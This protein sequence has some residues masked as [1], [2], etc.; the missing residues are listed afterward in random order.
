MPSHIGSEM[1]FLAESLHMRRLGTE[2]RTVAQV[3][4][5]QDHGSPRPA[6]RLPIA[7]LTAPGTRMG[8]MQAAFARALT[9]R[10]RPVLADVP[11]EG[12]P[13]GRVGR[14]RAWHR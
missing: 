13:G 4:H 8:P 10:L 14:F 11:R 2:R 7:F 5:G 3:R 9:L 1:A 6:G 12:P